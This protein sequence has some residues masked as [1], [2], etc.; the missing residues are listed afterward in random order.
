MTNFAENQ[1][2]KVILLRKNNQATTGGD[3]GFSIVK[4]NSQAHVIN[5]N[6]FLMRNEN[7]LS[8]ITYNLEQD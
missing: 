6:K 3:E 8:P 2:M 1:T 4:N 7:S 5:K